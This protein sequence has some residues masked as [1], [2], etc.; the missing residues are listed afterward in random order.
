MSASLGSSAAL[1]RDVCQVLC[2]FPRVALARPPRPWQLSCSPA[3][4]PRAGV[5]S[6]RGLLACPGHGDQR[7]SLGGGQPRY[8]GSDRTRWSCRAFLSQGTRELRG[9]RRGGRFLGCILSLGHRN[10]FRNFLLFL[11]IPQKALFSCVL[12]R[13]RW[14]PPGRGPTSWQPTWQPL[15]PQDPQAPPAS[16]DGLG[17][18]EGPCGR[19]P[20]LS[21]AVASARDADSHA[22][23]EPCPTRADGRLLSARAARRPGP[24]LI[25]FHFFF[26]FPPCCK[27]KRFPL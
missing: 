3:A 19:T 25:L 16:G 13:S 10:A 5:L 1:Q 7:P 21:R 11:Q 2:G 24:N 17:G 12:G 20:C 23:T 14:A 26:T 22:P 15:S 8:R 18:P 4:Y 9:E 27:F 6:A